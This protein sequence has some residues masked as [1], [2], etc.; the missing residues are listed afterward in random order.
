MSPE[1]TLAYYLP[2]VIHWKPSKEAVQ[3]TNLIFLAQKNRINEGGLRE[4]LERMNAYES[5]EKNP[6]RAFAKELCDELIEF[7]E[8]VLRGRNQRTRRKKVEL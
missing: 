1:D 3:R 6:P 5:F 2:E 7:L 8:D 4:A